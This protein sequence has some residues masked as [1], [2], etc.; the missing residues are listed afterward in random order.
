M[1]YRGFSFGYCTCVRLTEVP[2][3]GVIED[4]YYRIYIR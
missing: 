4:D 2:L 3:L 1:L